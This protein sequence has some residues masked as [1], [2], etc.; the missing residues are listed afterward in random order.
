MRSSSSPPDRVRHSIANVEK[1]REPQSVLTA[2]ENPD[3]HVRM[4]QHVQTDN[5]SEQTIPPDYGERPVRNIS[6]EMG[7]EPKAVTTRKHRLS[8]KADFTRLFT[9]QPLTVQD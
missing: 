6:K 8:V 5:Q 3:A 4:A 7:V 1:D 2:W 9:L